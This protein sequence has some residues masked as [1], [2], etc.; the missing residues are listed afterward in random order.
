MSANCVQETFCIASIQALKISLSRKQ[1]NS[2]IFYLFRWFE[3]T[4][5]VVGLQ[6]IIIAAQEFTKKV[7]CNEQI[8]KLKNVVLHEFD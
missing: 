6:E 3:F 5:I 8:M 4:I 7:I 2:Q 1:K